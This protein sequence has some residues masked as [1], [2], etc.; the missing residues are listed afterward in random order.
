[1]CLVWTGGA[2]LCSSKFSADVDLEGASTVFWLPRVHIS[3]VSFFRGRTAPTC[4]L[5]FDF[6]QKNNLASAHVCS[7]Q[8]TFKL[9]FKCAFPSFSILLVPYCCEDCPVC[10]QWN[11]SSG[12]RSMR[13]LYRSCH[14]TR[15]K[16]MCQPVTCVG[17]KAAF[18]SGFTNKWS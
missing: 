16:Y 7:V 8:L 14:P 11:A 6:C 5:I 1:M 3:F 10:F 2:I 9:L 13:A 15:P 4:I 18:P 17:P 12:I